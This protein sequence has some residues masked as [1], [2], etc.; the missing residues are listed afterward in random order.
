MAAIGFDTLT[1]A[2]GD[3]ISMGDLASKAD[4]AAL[5]A[6]L[7]AEIATVRAELKAEIAEVK[8]DILKW[9]FG[10]LIA[11]AALVVTLIK[12]LPGH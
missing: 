9:M 5:R 3:A 1:E 12:L 4:L 7:K 11:Q 8:A 2:I 10:A 6:D